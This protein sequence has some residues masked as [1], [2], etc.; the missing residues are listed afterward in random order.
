MKLRVA[1]GETGN[2]PLYGQRFT[3]LGISTNLNGFPATGVT[4]VAGDPDIHPERARE[5]EFGTDL[6]LFGGRATL[7][8]NLYQRQ[9]TDLL[10]QRS[11]APSTGFTTQFF[12]GGV[13][14]NR[15]IEIAL[16]GTP[17]QRDVRWQT[18][19]TF[20]LNRSQITSLP[21]RMAVISRNGRRLSELSRCS[22][23]SSNA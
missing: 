20:A 10:L 3:G 9:I 23:R 2:Q 17:V 21:G 14:R 18:G 7:E 19:V 13:L 11:V 4:G 12:N 16:E 22:R 8:L 6:S 15:G 5:I 1:Y